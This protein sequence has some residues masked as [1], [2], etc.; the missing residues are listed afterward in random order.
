MFSRRKKS[1]PNHDSTAP[2]FKPKEE[3]ATAGLAYRTTCCEYA[4]KYSKR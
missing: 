1:L 2:K 4:L 3:C